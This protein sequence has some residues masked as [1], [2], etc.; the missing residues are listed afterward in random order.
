[1]SRPLAL[2]A[3]PLKA[4][5]SPVVVTRRGL[6]RCWSMLG[7]LPLLAFASPVEPATLRCTTGEEKTLN[8][9]HTRCDDGTCA[10]SRYNMPL[11]RWETTMTSNPCPSCTA[12]M[13]RNTRQVELH[14]R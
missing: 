6:F 4:S 13:H 2:G 3:S 7:W 8:R 1:M 14:C 11:E 5:A 9:F 12:R 10:V